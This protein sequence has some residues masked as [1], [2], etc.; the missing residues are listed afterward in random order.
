MASF[1]DTYVSPYIESFSAGWDY[2]DEFFTEG[3]DYESSFLYT[4]GDYAEDIY[5]ESGLDVLVDYAGT[6]LEKGAGLVSTYKEGAKALSGLWSDGKRPTVSAKPQR[7]SSPSVQSA[8]SFTS[9]NARVGVNNPTVRQGMERLSRNSDI[10]W[11]SGLIG[12]QVSPTS[13]G[14]RRNINLEPSTI[15]MRK[16]TKQVS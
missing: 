4:V 10:P 1:W 7:V 9:S 16:A 15:T 14:G 8:G 6:A 5:D 13:R 11:V 3:V 2:G 12:G